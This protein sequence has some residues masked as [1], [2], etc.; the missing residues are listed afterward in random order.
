MEFI[1]TGSQAQFSTGGA[2]VF[3][4]PIRQTQPT[5]TGKPQ[6]PASGKVLSGFQWERPRP[7]PNSSSVWLIYDDDELIIN[8]STPCLGKRPQRPK[9]KGPGRPWGQ[10]PLAHGLAYLSK[11]PSGAL[12][13]R[14]HPGSEMAGHQKQP[15]K[16]NVFCFLFF[17]VV[18]PSPGTFLGG[19]CGIALNSTTYTKAP[20]AWLGG[21]IARSDANPHPG[22]RHWAGEPAGHLGAESP[23]RRTAE[24]ASARKTSPPCKH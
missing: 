24:P 22:L 20:P 21:G 6:S 15:R 19:G 23:S 5:H 10:K 8:P 4:S 2:F 1:P 7:K 16:R 13:R 11:T 17:F 9:P 14:G 18:A 12:F 3:G